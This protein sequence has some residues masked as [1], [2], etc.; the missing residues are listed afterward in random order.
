MKRTIAV[1][2]SLAAS[3][4]LWAG[5]IT[6]ESN[7]TRDAER[8]KVEFEN[9]AAARIFYETLSRG[10][11]NEGQRDSTTKFE[12]PVVFEYKRHTTTGPNAAFNHAVE[13]CDTNHD[14]KIT[15]GEAKIFAEWKK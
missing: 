15:E 12:I 6:H 10:S 5:C 4:A 9:D 3:A 2:G 14:G 1:Y 7:T 11:C 8:T 13:L